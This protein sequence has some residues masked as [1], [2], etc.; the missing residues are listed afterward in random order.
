VALKR[1]DIPVI[2]PLGPNPRV[3]VDYLEMS[4][5]RGQF[6]NFG[7]L[8]NLL[9]QRLADRLQVPSSNVVVFSNATS[10]LAAALATSGRKVA[11]IPDLSFVATL[12]AVRQ[13][14]L[15]VRVDDVSPDTWM[16]PEAETA[17]SDLINVPVLPFGRVDSQLL[18]SQSLHPMV[19]D[20]A[21]SL[22]GDWNL[23]DIKSENSVVFS[24]HATKPLGSGEGGIAVFGNS[25]WARSAR[26]WS[27]F[28]M[29]SS[30]HITQVGTNAKMSEFQA[31]FCL[32]ALDNWA[33]EKHEWLEAND[34]AIQASSRLGL[35]TLLKSQA[36][37]ISSY[38]IVD[39][40]SIKA[41][42]PRIVDYFSSQ[43]IGT[44]SWWPHSLGELVGG[45]TKTYSEE[46]RRGFLG[47]PM[48][49]RITKKE[50]ESVAKTTE[51]LATLG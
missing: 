32:S 30:R 49:R 50:V 8:V 42:L 17:D 11:R 35:E 25:D 27:N 34:L 31:A 12:S 46:F 15:S 20:G 40:R 4:F 1:I 21:A 36:G 38:W 7:P 37:N 44:R 48:Y 51:K 16:L 9:E 13:A 41:T 33:E 45:E 19:V 5:A 47:L 26:E 39:F 22:G 10:A 43:G 2:R 24:M 18:G 28:G 23:A 29:N 6:S 14:G 3:A